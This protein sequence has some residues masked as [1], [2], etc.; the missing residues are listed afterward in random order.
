MLKWAGPDR[1]AGPPTAL[2]G[3]RLFQ[4]FNLPKTVPLLTKG[5]KPST[6]VCVILLLLCASADAVVRFAAFDELRPIM[7]RMKSTAAQLEQE[8]TMLLRKLGQ[9]KITRAEYEKLIVTM[10][11]REQDDSGTPTVHDDRLLFARE[12][13]AGKIT[14]KEYDTI[15]KQHTSYYSSQPLMAGWLALG[16]EGADW[17]ADSVDLFDDKTKAQCQ[18]L[19]QQATQLDT[20]IAQKC[21]P[22]LSA[23]DDSLRQH[24]QTLIVGAEECVAN[25]ERSG[26][27]QTL[28]AFWS[29]PH[30][31][32]LRDLQV[33]GVC[34]TVV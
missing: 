32:R 2:R 14:Q 10:Q 13:L 25:I 28:A 3:Y 16:N 18:L 29:S 26:I 21:A 34:L 12:L 27:R 11:I 5:M 7:E 33:A 23:L 24:V 4:Y 22:H 9:G 30:G 31:M 19:L 6:M 17:T 15:V 20:L 1:W 8:R